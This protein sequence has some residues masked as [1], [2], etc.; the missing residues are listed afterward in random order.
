MMLVLFWVT[1][2]TAL[3][4]ILRVVPECRVSAYRSSLWEIRDEIVDRRL[5]GE[6]RPS[7]A[8]SDLVRD[9]E[10]R[11]RFARSL[12]PAVLGAALLG[13]R[14]APIDVPPSRKP[15]TAADQRDLNDYY[16]RVARLDTLQ[17]FSGYPSG[18]LLALVLMPLAVVLVVVEAVRRGSRTEGNHRRSGTRI[19]HR[20]EKATVLAVTRP[21]HSSPERDDL[22]VCV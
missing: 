16:D 18:W 1:L 9:I 11:I 17:L 20:V 12:R 10:S 4:A 19:E 5:R 15:V 6:I 21:G 2:V 3:L 22:A 13:K 7:A 14:L 8:A